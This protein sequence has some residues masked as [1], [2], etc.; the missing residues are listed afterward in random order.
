METILEKLYFGEI[1]PNSQLENLNPDL[2]KK[3]GEFTEMSEELI[4][5]LSDSEKKLLHKLIN[6]QSEIEGN[7]AVDN[8][9]HG[10]KMGVKIM[11][12]CL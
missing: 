8:F 7:I 4:S 12:Q 11:A 9:V 1:Q 3:V 6:T 5:I 2:S 10:F